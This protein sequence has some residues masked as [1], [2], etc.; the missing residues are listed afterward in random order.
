MPFKAYYLPLDGYPVDDV[1]IYSDGEGNAYYREIEIDKK[2]GKET[3]IKEIKGVLIEDA[4]KTIF[5]QSYYKFDAEGEEDDFTC[6][7]F[8]N[9]QANYFTRYTE[10]YVG[11]YTGK[12]GKSKIKIDGYQGGITYTDANGYVYE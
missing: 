1:Y 4:G 8:S 12:D 3:I 5:G 11:T 2:T 7:I 10:E 9:G 6:R